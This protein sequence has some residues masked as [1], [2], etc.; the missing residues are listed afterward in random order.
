MHKWEIEMNKPIYIGQAILDI[1]KTLMYEFHYGFVKKNFPN[2]Q[3]KLL[4]VY[5]YGQFVLSN[6]EF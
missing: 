6:I 1:S 4:I 5:G 2:K 3:A